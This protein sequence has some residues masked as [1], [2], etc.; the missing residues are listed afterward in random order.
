MRPPNKKES[1]RYKSLQ[2]FKIKILP[3]P[4]ASVATGLSPPHPRCECRQLRF[5]KPGVLVSPRRERKDFE[6]RLY[7]SGIT[8]IL[9]Q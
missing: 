4:G 2:S 1:Y 3:A 7:P 6:K 9:A 8:S 5:E